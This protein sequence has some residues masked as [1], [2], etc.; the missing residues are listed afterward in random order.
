MLN[1]ECSDL[2]AHEHEGAF[3]LVFGF[4]DVA[5]CMVV[6]FN[7]PGGWYA[8]SIETES[9]AYSTY[10]NVPHGMQRMLSDI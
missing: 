7:N 9:R 1:H 6:D 2:G 5:V 3:L 10:C 8:Y 4:R